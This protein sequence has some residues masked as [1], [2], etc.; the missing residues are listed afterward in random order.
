MAVFQGAESHL[1]ADDDFDEAATAMQTDST[2]FLLLYENRWAGP[3]A[4]A[5]RKGGGRL[6]ASGRLPVQ[7]ILAA[8]DATADYDQVS[9]NATGERSSNHHAR[10]HS[11]C[12]A[13]RGHRG[14][15]DC[16][17]ESSFTPPG[18]SLGGPGA[19][20]VRQQ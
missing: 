18:G 16:G 1:L 10:S 14:N 5:M 6:I 2:A 17:F 7:A 9:K 15:R 4:S 19:A 13:D 8:L 12:C 3:F 11:R 20:A